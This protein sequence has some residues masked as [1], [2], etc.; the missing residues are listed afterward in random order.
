MSVG[1]ESKHCKTCNKCINGFDHH[2]M[3][4]NNC[5]GKSNYKK[6]IYFISVANVSV[7]FS[8]I[9]QILAIVEINN[10]LVDPL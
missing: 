1:G 2:C 6:F 8:L 9:I 5:I 10:E 3:W 7:L 4:L